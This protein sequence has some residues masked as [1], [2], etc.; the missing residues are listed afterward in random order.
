MY[1]L[2]TLLKQLRPGDAALIARNN[3]TQSLNNINNAVGI[4]T[5]VM[6]TAGNA[7]VG[8]YD[9]AAIEAAITTLGYLVGTDGGKSV[10]QLM[11]IGST[12]HINGIIV[13][14]KVWQASDQAVRESKN[15]LMLEGL[16]YS[17]E[18]LLR[19]RDRKLGEGDPIPLTRENVEIIRNKLVK[20]EQFREQFRVY[21][22]D[23]LQRPWPKPGFWASLW[24]PSDYSKRKNLSKERK[25][26]LIT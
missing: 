22:A 2:I 24:L 6:N 17:T 14:F 4:L 1:V 16:Y 3:L 19:K 5:G 21:L 10:L 20:D 11:K 23:E 25:S 9:D 18:R 12:A 15:A 26:F 8:K 13:A 7:W